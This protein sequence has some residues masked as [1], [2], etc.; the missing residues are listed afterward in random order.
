MQSPPDPQPVRP[1]IL[2]EIR[3]M[4]ETI[5]IDHMLNEG[6]PRL[7]TFTIDIEMQPFISANKPFSGLIIPVD[8]RHLLP[9]NAV[10]IRKKNG[11]LVVGIL[12]DK[13]TSFELTRNGQSSLIDKDEVTNTFLI[14]NR[15]NPNE[16]ISEATGL[17]LLHSTRSHDRIV[18]GRLFELIFAW[19]FWW[20]YQK[21]NADEAANTIRTGMEDLIKNTQQPQRLSLLELK[22]YIQTIDKN[23]NVDAALNTNPANRP[24]YEEVIGTAYEAFRPLQEERREILVSE[25]NRRLGAQLDRDETDESSQNMAEVAN[26]LPKQEQGSKGLPARQF[27]N[28]TDKLINGFTEADLNGLLVHMRIKNLQG[29]LLVFKKYILHSVINALVEQKYLDRQ[30]IEV[31]FIALLKFLGMPEKFT[32]E[33]YGKGEVPAT[34]KAK[35]YLITNSLSA[36]KEVKKKDFK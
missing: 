2:R 36:K 21:K 15:Q 1:G 9:F 4:C 11:K 12:S 5:G 19:L 17:N 3:T 18:K 20:D 30:S 32:K 29:K 26:D 6:A 35:T 24:H 13:G 33:G 10:A 22:Y 25:L 8:F 7:N 31:D 14:D 16:P 28:F 27:D 23:L 34:E